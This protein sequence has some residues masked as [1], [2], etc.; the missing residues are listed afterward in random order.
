MSC[1]YTEFLADLTDPQVRALASQ[2]GIAGSMTYPVP[3][4]Y[5]LLLDSDQ[6][7]EIYSE[8]FGA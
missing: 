7:M 1:E 5:T 6:A 2:S 8:V 3:K 4:L